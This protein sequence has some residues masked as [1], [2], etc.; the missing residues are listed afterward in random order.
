MMM[1]FDNALE[2]SLQALRE[3]RADVGACL[4]QHPEHAEALRPLLIAAERLIAA[5]DTAE[6]S[7][8]FAAAA[9]ER[10]RVATGERITETFDIEP[11]PSF[12]AAARVKFLMAAQRMR[13]GEKANRPQP[14]LPVFGSAY[15]ALGATAAAF[16]LFAGLSG[17]TVASASDALPGETLYGVKLQ[18][19]RVRLALAFTEGAERDVRLD[20]AAERVDEIEEL[21]EK[22][23]IIGPGVIDR[24]KEDTEPLADD[25]ENNE[26]DAGEIRRVQ[27]ITVKSQIVLDEAEEQVSD[28]AQPLLAETRAFVED[29][30]LRA[31]EEAVNATDGPVR[32]TPTNPEET[33]EPTDTPESTPTPAPA[34]TEA[35]PTSEPSPEPT[36]TTAP[37]RDGLAID[38]TPVGIDRGVTWIRLS[39]GLFST[40]IPSPQD[41]WNIAG[42][43]ITDGSSPAPKLIRLYNAD[44]TQMITINPKNGDTY[45]FVAVNGVFDEVQLRI[46]RDGQVYVVD[47]DLITRLYG[48]LSDIPLYVID[49]MEFAPEPPPP[50][51]TPPTPQP[52]TPSRSEPQVP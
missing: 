24:L 44:G 3:G 42:V 1:D 19:E 26:L 2:S 43:N 46:E 22:G 35:P 13:L 28:D 31:G 25:L 5:Y 12:F 51:P 14:R 33:P 17:Y 15:K 16:V 27:D 52:T 39:S 30:A 47:R 18:T 6:P 9:R 10:F 50:P 34:S 37:S 45:W 32:I 7:E 29:V 36:A 38:P 40:L 20:I 48:P 8:G 4:A 23:R 21:T 11:S 41:G 49:N